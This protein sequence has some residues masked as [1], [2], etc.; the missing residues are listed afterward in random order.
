M[1]VGGQECRP[2]CQK[3]RHNLKPCS[4]SSA[5]DRAISSRLP[6]S[7]YHTTHYIT[8]TTYTLTTKGITHLLFCLNTFISKPQV[9]QYLTTGDLLS[10]AACVHCTTSGDSTQVNHHR[11]HMKLGCAPL[12]QL[13]WC[14]F[15]LKWCQV[16]TCNRS[17]E[18]TQWALCV[19]SDGV[20]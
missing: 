5:A 18:C 2:C 16:H 13:V 1:A 20:L 7:Q 10:P 15:V 4:Q 17:C 8:H 9:S 3:V 6:L 12:P 14:V 19:A 11:Q